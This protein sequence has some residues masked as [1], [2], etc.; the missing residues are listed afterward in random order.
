MSV[1]GTYYLTLICLLLFHFWFH[2]KLHKHQQ[3]Q[4]FMFSLQQL[5]KCFENVLKNMVYFGG[6]KS[7][8]LVQQRFLFLQTQ[9]SPDRSHIIQW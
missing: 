5:I 3:R 9:P 1:L 4:T 7:N 6:T 2:L 8:S